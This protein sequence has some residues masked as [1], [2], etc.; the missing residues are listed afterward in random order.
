VERRPGPGAVGDSE[1][2][3]DVEGEDN[4]EGDESWGQGRAIHSG[5]GRMARLETPQAAIHPTIKIYNPPKPKKSV[6]IK[7]C[8]HK[9]RQ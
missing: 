1:E 2:P 3:D 6:T 8:Y 9:K 4:G 5:G 7:I